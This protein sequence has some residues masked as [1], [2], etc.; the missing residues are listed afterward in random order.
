M[1]VPFKRVSAA[2]GY[3]Y[4]NKPVYLRTSIK[5]LSKTPKLAD[6]TPSCTRGCT[7]VKS[8]IHRMTRQHIPKEH[9]KQA[10]LEGI[11]HGLSVRVVYRALG[12]EPQMRF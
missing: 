8:N 10:P 12:L 3:N 2:E 9:S 6:F 11:G 4:A 7:R 1:E 5:V